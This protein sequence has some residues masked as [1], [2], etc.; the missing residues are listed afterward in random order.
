MLRFLLNYRASQI[1]EVLVHHYY[2]DK[3]ISVKKG[4]EVR[5]LLR[6]NKRMEKIEK[7]VIEPYL[8][9]RRINTYE[10]EIIPDDVRKI[11]INGKEYHLK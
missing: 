9:S 4:D 11:V 2:K 1:N 7:F 10:T 6:P 8:T 3:I 5:F